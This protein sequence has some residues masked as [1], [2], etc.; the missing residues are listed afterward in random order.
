[1]G[2]LYFAKTVLPSMVEK[3]KGH[4]VFVSSAIVFSPMGGYTAYGAT[5][6]AVKGTLSSKYC[7][8]V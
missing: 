4:I 5:K 8:Y 6:C 1:M 2:Y 7:I 3:K